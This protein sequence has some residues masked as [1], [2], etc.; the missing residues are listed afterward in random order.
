MQAVKHIIKLPVKPW[1]LVIQNLA[2]C[3]VE[4]K[5]FSETPI[6]R[7]PRRLARVLVGHSGL[8]GTKTLFKLSWIQ[9][10]GIVH[11]DTWNGNQAWNSDQKQASWAEVALCSRC[12][13]PEDATVICLLAS[14]HILLLPFLLMT[15]FF[16]LYF[17]V[18]FC[19]IWLASAFSFSWKPFSFCSYRYLSFPWTFCHSNPWGAWLTLS[20]HSR[21]QISSVCA[22]TVVPGQ[23]QP[24]SI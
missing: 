9:V 21:P 3:S 13:A 4:Q 16:N 5:V 18:C 20:F 2:H 24:Y 14:L 22:D 6:W 19:V 7:E 12:V 8:Q 1:H 11:Q 17:S 15:G 10:P 23:R